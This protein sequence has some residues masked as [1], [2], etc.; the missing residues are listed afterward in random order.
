MGTWYSFNA[1][2]ID[3]YS[4]SW[5]ANIYF[6]ELNGDIS[7][8]NVKKDAWANLAAE[9]DWAWTLDTLYIYS[10]TDPNARYTSVEMSQRTKSISINSK[11]YVTIDGIEC[12]YGG[13]AGIE[14]L[15]NNPMLNLSGLI[16][17]NCH[18]H[19]F[20]IKVGAGYG[21]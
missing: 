18:L 13:S 1:A 2:Y 21:G 19:H 8:G 9:Y 14:D 3:P 11:E 15:Y 10:P 6:K 20:G 16:I 12:A 17:K 5:D 7:W 4:L